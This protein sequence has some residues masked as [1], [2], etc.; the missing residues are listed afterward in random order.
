MSTPE[1]Q[2]PMVIKPIASSA[3]TKPI[4][5]CPVAGCGARSLGDTGCPNG[6]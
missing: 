3:P 6:H 2:Q 4:S 1:T 5:V